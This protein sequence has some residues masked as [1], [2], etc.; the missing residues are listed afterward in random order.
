M[1]Q[2]T[3]SEVITILLK[4]YIQDK[5]VLKEYKNWYAKQFYKIPIEVIN[6]LAKE[7]EATGK[8]KARLF[9]HL[10]KHEVKERE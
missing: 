1:D 10:I 5:L 3:R 6:Q 4:N 2:L 9:C 8:D 7:A